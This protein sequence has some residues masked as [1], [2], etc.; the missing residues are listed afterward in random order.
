MTD[1][2][3][4]QVVMSEHLYVTQC[5]P[6]WTLFRRGKRPK[7]LGMMF[8]QCVPKGAWRYIDEYNE[9]SETIM[10]WRLRQKAKQT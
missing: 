7:F 6:H 8:G 10:A 3:E 4:I 1:F 5:G 9:L 2:P